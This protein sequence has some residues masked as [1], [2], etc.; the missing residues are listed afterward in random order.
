MIYKIRVILDT[1]EDVFRDIAICYNDT[2]EDLHNAIANAF[3]FEGNEMAAF[4]LTDNEWNQGEEI[5]LFDM[6]D[7]GGGMSMQNFTIKDVLPEE[8][9]KLIYVYDFLSMWTFYV[10][11]MTIEENTEQF[12]LPSLLFSVGSVPDEA[13]EKEFKSER[14]DDDGYD[15][16][17]SYDDFDELMN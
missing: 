9:N 10:E 7:T 14:L 5:P 17:E 6:E 4:Y 1:K 2:L 8:E 12:E 16:F 13:P 3:G 15:S 11:L